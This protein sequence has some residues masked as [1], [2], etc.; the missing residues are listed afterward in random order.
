MIQ[1]LSPRKV[2]LLA[3]VVLFVHMLFLQT[4]NRAKQFD[5]FST[6]L[7][8]K[9]VERAV[10][11]K[12][13]YFENGFMYF[14]AAAFR[15]EGMKLDREEDYPYYSQF[16]LHY[17][18]LALFPR[19][20]PVSP[21]TTF[22]LARLVYLALSAALLGWM[23]YWCAARFNPAAGIVFTVLMLGAT[24]LHLFAGNLYWASF[25]LLLPFA[26][27]LNVYPAW[28]ERWGLFLGS[29]GLMMMLKSLCGYEYLSVMALA[30][31]APVV[32]YELLRETRLFSILKRVV[33]V[34]VV[35]VAGFAA[36]LVLHLWQRSLAPS[37]TPFGKFIVKNLGGAAEDPATLPVF[38]R[39]FMIYLF[40]D[41]LVMALGVTGLLL[42]LLRYGVNLP[43]NRVERRAYA[44]F[45]LMSVAAS[46]SWNCLMWGH[47]KNHSH[48]NGITFYMCWY[49]VL[50]I[51]LSKIVSGV[52]FPGN[53][54][55]KGTT[56]GMLAG[57]R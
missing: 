23:A 51:I 11:E 47:M 25:W 33:Q 21:K 5:S 52:F 49:P 57:E 35:S 31:A 6:L 46:F 20:L 53:Q 38:V 28:R 18:V 7:I 27:S 15:A 26:F 43:M 50:F 48:L 29:I 39:R 16:G 24:H 45:L 19:F 17:K 32:F 2:A 4:S 10:A 30:A 8:T 37:P 1:N 12:N 3:T 56:R 9:W 14:D 54:G 41:G 13:I 44:G 36:A 40:A 34:G 22:F 55:V 42:Y